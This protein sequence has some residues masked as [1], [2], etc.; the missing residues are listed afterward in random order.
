MTLLIKL[1]MVLVPLV[2]VAFGVML[3]IQAA[4]FWLDVIGPPKLTPIE[5][6]FDQATT[7]QAILFIPESIRPQDSPISIEVEVTQIALEELD[8]QIEIIIADS[9]DYLKVVNSKSILTFN[10][11]STRTQSAITTLNVRNIWN[12]PVRCELLVNVNAG[13]AKAIG[14]FDLPVNAWIGHSLAV[15]K[16]LFGMGT[17]ILGLKGLLG[18]F[19]IW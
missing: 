18:V 6:R 1:L 15:I 5:L 4:S 10:A 13:Q 14:V 2:V 12:P 19:H 7:F 3:V 8:E 16:L 17:S 9:C 11:Q